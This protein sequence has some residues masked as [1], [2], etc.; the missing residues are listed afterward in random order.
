MYLHRL[1]K[2][3]SGY[4]GLI[5]TASSYEWFK[6]TRQGR[7]N[8]LKVYPKEDFEDWEHFKSIMAKFV[9]GRSFFEP[10]IPMTFCSV[11]ELDRIDAT[12][13]SAGS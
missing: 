11:Q 5:E 4:L 6:L 1:S 13:L 9:P 3:R 2:Y 8:R 12:Y 7:L 10:P